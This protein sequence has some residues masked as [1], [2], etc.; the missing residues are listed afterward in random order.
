[1][2]LTEFQ[3]WIAKLLSKN[4]SFDSHLAG[5]AAM[6]FEPNS[7]RFSND[8]DYFH[9]SIER[10]ATAF[11]ADESELRLSGCAVA[12]EVKQPGY[13]RATISHKNGSTKIEWAHD[14][15]WRFFPV[16]QNDA[17]GFVL[18]PI[19]L[20]INKVLALAGRNEPRD[21]L[22]V[23]HV[24]QNILSLGALCWA[25]VAKDP[26]FTPQSLLELL[27]RRG[28][29]HQ[30]DF[31]R[32][33]LAQ[34]VDLNKLKAEWLEAL[35]LADVFVRSRPSDEIGCLYLSKAT[36]DFFAPTLQDKYITHFATPGGILPRIS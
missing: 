2:P 13:I 30:E 1:M 9:D 20:A 14:S 7:I 6:H 24:H 29:F 36:H 31:K 22:D 12:V 3:Q 32:L 28:K 5:G 18:H 10:V 25:A 4:R 16:V 23:I 35:D 27:K 26:G 17:L 8:L 34:P 11:E 19:D 21:F 33:K 15:D